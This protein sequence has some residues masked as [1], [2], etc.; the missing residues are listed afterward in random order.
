MI[1]HFWLLILVTFFSFFFIQSMVYGSELREN[2]R[3]TNNHL[4][5]CSSEVACVVSWQEESQFYIAPISYHITRNQAKEILLKVLTVVP[6]TK[7]IEIKDNYIL[8]ESKGKFLGGIYEVEFYFPPNLSVIELR[9]ASRSS[10][11]DLGVNR[12]RLEQIRLALKDL[13]I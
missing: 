12:R 3:I 2:E 10:K 1:R 8:A 9:S 7:V 4:L 5:P 13:N 6:R 11:F